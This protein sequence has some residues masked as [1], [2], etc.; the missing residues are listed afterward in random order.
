MLKRPEAAYIT[1]IGRAYMQIGNDEIFE[2]FQSGYAGAMYEPKEQLELS[3]HSEV[4]MIALDGSKLVT[5]RRKLSTGG[6]SQLDAAIQYI[7]KVAREE[8]IHSVKPLWLPV[9]ENKIFLEDIYEC[10][11]IQEE[12][13]LQA[14][15]GVVDQREIQLRETGSIGLVE[16]SQYYGGWKYWKR[17]NNI[18]TDNV[19]FVIITVSG[20]PLQFL[21]YGFLQ[22]NI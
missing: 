21:L 18:P 4:N 20:R 8:G 9:L 1:G 15:V 12:S 2:M 22:Q 5:P 11:P 7:T 3:Q 13:M 17:K 6:I 14:V 10:Y 19:I 16:R